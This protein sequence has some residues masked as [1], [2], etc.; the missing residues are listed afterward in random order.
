[1][2]G[3]SKGEGRGKNQENP[4]NKARELSVNQPSR[5]V[6]SQKTTN[7]NMDTSSFL[8]ASSQK[9][10]A[11]ENSPHPGTEKKRGRDTILLLKPMR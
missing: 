6:V 10:F 11:I 7:V 2:K 8:A 9:D 1:M 5:F 4:K 3:G